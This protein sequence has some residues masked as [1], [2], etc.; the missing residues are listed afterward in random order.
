LQ[1]IHDRLKGVYQLIQ[2]INT[3]HTKSVTTIAAINKIHEKARQDEKITQTNKQKLKTL[4]NNAISEAETEEDLIR[5]TLEKIYEIRSIK[6]E[7][8]I[9]AK[10]AGNKEA[11]RR[12]ALMKMLQTSAQTLPLWIGKPGQDPPPLC[13][14][15]P[16]EFSY[17]AKV[18]DMVAALV[19]S[20]EGDDN[21][22]LAEVVSYNSSLSKYEVDDIDEESKEHLTLSRRR[23]VPLPVLRANPETDPQALFP[24]DTVVMALYPQTTCFYKAVVNAPP[25]THND[26]YEILFEDSSYTEG[27]SPPL[28]VAQRYVIA[29]RDKKIKV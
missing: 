13:G 21:W 27:F 29:I 16:S 19:R 2:D 7:R 18:G 26:E 17:V 12:G 20:P 22:I 14:A 23:V 11:I 3:E 5:K 28:K 4:Y 1:Q 6:N 10:Q 25:Q 24:K 8:R 15:I 9:Q